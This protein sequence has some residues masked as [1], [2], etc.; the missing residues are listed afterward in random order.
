[1]VGFSHQWKGASFS[2][3]SL[4]LETPPRHREVVFSDTQGF[5]EQFSDEVEQSV[6]NLDLGNLLFLVK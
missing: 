3:P 1:M 4:S 2:V 6:A 5:L